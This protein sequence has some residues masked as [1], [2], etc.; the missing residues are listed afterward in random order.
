MNLPEHLSYSSISTYLMCPK[1]WEYRYLIK[2]DAPTS[3]NLIFG[4]AFHNAIEH[5]L[6][7]GVEPATMWNEIGRASCRER[8]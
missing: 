1:S 4:S 6:V 5:A 7:K 2:P 3:A 8:V